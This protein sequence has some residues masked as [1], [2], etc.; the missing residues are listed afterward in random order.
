[1]IL[2]YASN[3]LQGIPLTLALEAVARA[4]FRGVEILMDAPHW[5]VENTARQV[6]AL[7]KTLSITGLSLNNLNANDA[8]LL[9]LPR[10]PEPRPLDPE[11]AVRKRVLA[12][13]RDLLALAQDLGSPA[14]SIATGPLPGR[15]SRTQAED[16][17]RYHLEFLLKAAEGGP[18]MVTIEFE[19]GHH[20]NSWQSIEGVLQEFN[21][22][23][24]GCNFDIGH[25]ACAGELLPE[26]L[27]KALPRVRNIH[28]EDIQGRRHE[29]LVPGR[30][31]LPL[32]KILESL[33]DNG[34]KGGVTVELYNH[35]HRGEMAL[36]ETRDWFLQHAPN[37]LRLESKVR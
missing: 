23:L 27:A 24:L 11:P 2:G 26:T 8:R 4:G 5:T 30:G 35:S 1:M 9:G 15:I 6:T 22:P 31:D 28:F 12:W 21:H 13:H 3:S 32:P 20:W 14:L 25:A 7:R 36:Q 17:L 10:L 34:Y 18:T 19:P 33:T 16:L 37:L 29:H